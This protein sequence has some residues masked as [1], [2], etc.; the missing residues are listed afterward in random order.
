MSKAIDQVLSQ[1]VESGTL[2]GVTA[3]AANRDGT[4]YEGSF[5]VRDL[6]QRSA[7]TNDT[8]MWIASMTKAITGAAAMQLVEQ[9]KLTLDDPASKVIPELG[10]V[11]V[12]TGFDGDGAPELRPPKSDITLRNLLTHTSGYGYDIWSEDLCRY[13]EAT[14]TPG[15]TGCENAALTTPLLFD[16]GT[17]WM[18]GIGIDW[19]GKLIEAASGQTLGRYMKENILEPL[20]MTSTGFH[21]TDDMRARLSSVHARGE[22]DAL[23]VFPLEITQE[24]EFEMGG[25]GLYSNVPDYLRFTRAILNGGELDGNRILAPET[26][27]AMAENSI[28]DIDV[29]TLHTA[30]PPFSNDANLFPGMTQKWGLTFLIN[31]EESAEGRSAGSLAWAGLANSYYWIDREKDVCGVWATQIVPFADEGSLDNFRQFERAVYNT[32]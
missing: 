3:A 10:A 14:D 32:L 21:I 31:T 7:M 18:Y 15:V 28:G 1:G 17:A 20:A 27:D 22:D 24:P 2:A 26:I 25:G 16:P 29:V 12:L 9:G 5:G 30:I 8:V 23:G 4:I 11:Q 6:D 13:Q 19:A